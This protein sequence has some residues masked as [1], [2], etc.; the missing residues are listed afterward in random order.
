MILASCWLALPS[1]H[2]NIIQTN[3]IKSINSLFS[4][5]SFSHRSS[6][7]C[8]P[9]LR[10][11]TMQRMYI[12]VSKS[13]QQRLGQR[14]TVQ[15][16]EKWEKSTR[17]SEAVHH[18]MHPYNTHSPHSRKIRKMHGTS[19]VIW[20]EKKWLSSRGWKMNYGIFLDI[21]LH[22]TTL[23]CLLVSPSPQITPI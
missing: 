14:H 11:R 23:A 3:E 6:T 20:A 17:E 8:S 22:P 21:F 1:M 4:F 15:Q 5:S 12:I 7:I 13:K 18:L 16:W 10:A 19:I 9:S 2:P